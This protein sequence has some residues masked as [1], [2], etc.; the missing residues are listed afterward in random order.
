MLDYS[1]SRPTQSPT[2]HIYN[3]FSDFHTIFY[4]V[5]AFTG[6]PPHY[7]KTSTPSTRFNETEGM[8]FL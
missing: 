6:E 8:Y 4:I 3:I 7:T 1:I 5:E 2:Y